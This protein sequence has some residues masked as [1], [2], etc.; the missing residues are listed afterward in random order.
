MRRSASEIIRNLE[1]RVAR[2]ENKSAGRVGKTCVIEEMYREGRGG[3]QGEAVLVCNG[4][5]MGISFD[6]LGHSTVD[7]NDRHLRSTG[8]MEILDSLKKE[9][10]KPNIKEF[11]AKAVGIAGEEG[12]TLDACIQMA[13]F[14]DLD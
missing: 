2:L 12:M 11:I 8:A 13:S 6:T 10:R 3:G 5:R 14:M 7:G 1:M 9:Y 4:V